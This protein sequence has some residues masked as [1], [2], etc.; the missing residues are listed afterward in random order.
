[1]LKTTQTLQWNGKNMKVR[2]KKSVKMHSFLYL[3]RECSC[4]SAKREEKGLHT[5]SRR[6]TNT[7]QR[8]ASHRI[9]TQEHSTGCTNDEK[10]EMKNLMQ[11]DFGRLFFNCNKLMQ[12]HKSAIKCIISRAFNEAVATKENL[13]S[14]VCK[15]FYPFVLKD[16]IG[17]KVWTKFVRFSLEKSKLDLNQIQRLLSNLTKFGDCV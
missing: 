9:A 16:A 8:I 17:W 10:C 13:V 2:E 15:T 6:N 11:L 3:R 12:T 4:F 7:M 14:L 5:Q 1:M